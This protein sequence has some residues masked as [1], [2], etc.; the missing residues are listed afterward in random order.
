M[1][2]EGVAKSWLLQ[3]HL[4]SITDMVSGR[5]TM[6]SL[7]GYSTT[8]E[9][10]KNKS[11]TMISPWCHHDI[12]V[13]AP[14][15]L[16]SEEKERRQRAFCPIDVTVWSQPPTV[17]KGA[18]SAM[19]HGLALHGFTSKCLTLT[20]MTVCCFCLL[21]EMYAFSLQVILHPTPNSPKQ[22]EWHK[23]TVSKNCPD[24]DLKIKLAV[25]MDK[26]Q[27]MKHSG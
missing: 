4:F 23:M 9:F 14:I 12:T 10:Q 3:T 19:E 22:S 24:Q 13:L 15:D 2:K 25:R 7:L 20:S 11:R 17:H 8:S 5:W 6:F 16:A 26:P 21:T 1:E 18:V 27:N